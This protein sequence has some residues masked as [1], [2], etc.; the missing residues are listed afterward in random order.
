MEKLIDQR[1]YPKII[2]VALPTG[3]PWVYITNEPKIT[4]L[5]QAMKHFVYRILLPIS[6][7]AGLAVQPALAQKN[8]PVQITLEQIAERCKDLP[9]D[10]RLTVKVVRFSVSNTRAQEQGEFGGELATMLTNSLHKVNCFRVLETDGNMGDINDGIDAQLVVT[11]EVTEFS[12]K[13]TS[14]IGIQ[15]NKVSMG[16]ILKVLNP[17]TGDIL[18]SESVNGESISTGFSSEIFTTTRLSGAVANASEQAIIKATE[19]LANQK[20]RIEAPVMVAA[21]KFSPANCT[22]LKNGK[23]P[24]IMILIPETQTTGGIVIDKKLTRREQE[25][26]ER[27]ENREMLKTFIGAL[28]KK[29]NAAAQ[30]A[31]DNNAKKTVVLEQATAEGALINQFIEAGFRVIDPSMYSRLR[32]QNSEQGNDLAKM[33]ALGLKLGADIV[34]TGKANSEQVASKMEGNFSFRG[35]VE[36][37]ALLTEDAIVLATH[38]ENASADDRAES[39]AAQKAIR[40]ASAKMATYMLEQLCSRN[41]TFANNIPAS[42]SRPA[43]AVATGSSAH[44]TDIAV[45]NASFAKLQAL[46]SILTKNPKVKSVQKSLKGTEGSLHVEHIGTTDDLIELLGKN[47]TPKFDV[48]GMEEGKVSLTLN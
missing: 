39:I 21:K 3:H 26:K 12:E 17:Q 5:D 32:D 46:T 40:S 25:F 1:I 15:K 44:A 7:A 10:K 8:K 29:N 33:A 35:R 37:R 48:T 31:V 13:N 9:R 18:F 42:V 30:P 16:F 27:Q 24:K 45:A 38:S 43:S 28:S 47:P 11:G 22:L 23:G 19:V 6:V 41:L 20:D 34:I 2:D 36:L 14:L 4:L